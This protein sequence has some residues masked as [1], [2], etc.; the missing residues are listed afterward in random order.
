MTPPDLPSASE[1]MGEDG[2]GGGAGGGSGDGA[3]GAGG[4][5]GGGAGG[6]PGS[7]DPSHAQ[8]DTD[9][10]SERGF[11][12]PPGGIPNGQVLPAANGGAAG[13]MGGGMPMGGMPMG[14]AGMS[15]QGMGQER[16]RE[17]HTWLQAEGGIWDEDTDHL[18]P[19]VIGR[20]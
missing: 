15:P 6:G 8:F 1:L 14:G 20:T 13:P 7:L 12:T 4:G 19:G 17:P 3:G 16:E 11:S 10:A 18:A 9:V 2:T 5:L